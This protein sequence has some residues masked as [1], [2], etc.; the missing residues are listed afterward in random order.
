MIA[1]AERLFSDRL[2]KELSTDPA[3]NVALLTFYLGTSVMDG[4]QVTKTFR[5]VYQLVDGEW[6]RKG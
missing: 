6:Q 1:F 4:Q 2:H 5:V 3:A